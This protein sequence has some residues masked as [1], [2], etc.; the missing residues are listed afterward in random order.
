MLYDK[1]YPHRDKRTRQEN[2]LR[3]FLLGLQ[4]ENARMHV[5]LNRGPES[6]EEAVYFTIHY[7]ETCRYPDEDQYF[8][9]VDENSA[10]EFSI[11]DVEHNK[12][13]VKLYNDVLMETQT[14]ET[15][16]IVLNQSPSTRPHNFIENEHFIIVELGPSMNLESP[17][18]IAEP[19]IERQEEII[20]PPDADHNILEIFE[21]F[22]MQILLGTDKH[23]YTGAARTVL[24]EETYLRIPVEVRPP[25]VQSHSLIGAD[26]NPLKELGT[27]YFEV[28]LGN[29]SFNMELV[30]AH[31]ADN[32]LLGLDILVMGKKGPS[33]IR[34]GDKVLCWNEQNI[35]FKFVGEFTKVRKVIAA[36]YTVIPGYSEVIMEAY[37]EKTDLDSWFSHQEFLIEPFQNL[38]RNHL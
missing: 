3:K 15:S 9:T 17:V 14:E 2:L 29:F 12:P 23:I 18:N 1:C 26:G 25:L 28:R 10:N 5:D 30:V 4:D 16:N 22:E 27:A 24:S 35:P 20:M 11:V 8:I 37:V 36:D 7:Q 19:E 21:D 33:E 6:I 13:K 32:V 38:W 31:I 34:L